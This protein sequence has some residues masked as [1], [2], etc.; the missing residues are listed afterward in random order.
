MENDW[1]GFC[2]D[3]DIGIILEVDHPMNDWAHS[4][5]HDTLISYRLWLFKIFLRFLLPFLFGKFKIPEE[6][7]I[8]E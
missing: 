3:D 4:Y 8:L 6:F 2:P 7:F 5:L 1:L